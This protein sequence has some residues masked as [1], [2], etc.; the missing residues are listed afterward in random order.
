MSTKEYNIVGYLPYRKHNKNIEYTIGEN[1]HINKSNDKF[2]LSILFLYFFL[3]HI[4]VNI[5]LNILIVFPLVN[6]VAY[7]LFLMM[8]GF[9][10]SLFVSIALTYYKGFIEGMQFRLS[11][12]NLNKIPYSPI[13]TTVI[14]WNDKHIYTVPYDI[15]TPDLY[16]TLPHGILQLYNEA[17]DFKFTTLIQWCVVLYGYVYIFLSTLYQK[18]EKYF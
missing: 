3:Y 13:I 4:F 17:I 16:D 9:S 2:E 15:I 10:Q 1:V 7:P 14:T 12:F 6:I 8:N 18:F 11:D 5:G